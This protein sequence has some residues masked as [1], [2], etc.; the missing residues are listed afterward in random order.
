MKPESTLKVLVFDLH[1]ISR[2][3]IRLL[4]D[5]MDMRMKVTEAGRVRQFYKYATTQRFDLIV[6]SVNDVDSFDNELIGKILPKTVV[7]YTEEGAENAMDLMA[8]GGGAC[9]SKKCNDAALREGI[10][11][12]LQQRRYVCATTQAHVNAE[13]W[14]FRAIRNGATGSYRPR[15]RQLTSRESEI[16]SMLETGMKTGEIADRLQIQHSTVS[17]LKARAFRKLSMTN[18][19]QAI[20]TLE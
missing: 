20:H 5:T 10:S 16:A 4:L 17:T 13:Y 8:L 6:M 3:G 12:V 1:P 14:R 9:M 15:V 19:V 11:A 18:L 7:L 2:K